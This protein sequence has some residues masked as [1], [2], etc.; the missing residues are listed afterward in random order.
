VLLRVVQQEDVDTVEAHPGERVLEA[1]PH[2]VT[3][4]VPD[5]PMVRGHREQVRHV[6]AGRLLRLEHPADLRRHHELVPRPAPQEDAELAFRPAEA[7][8]R[9]DVVVADARIPP[10]R[11]GRLGIVARDRLEQAADRATAEADLR[12]GESGTARRDLPRAHG[13]T[14]ARAAARRQGGYLT[15]Q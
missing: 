2:A 13:S 11:Q 5:P 6:V 7:V 14:L 15:D 12:H 4:E 1:A 3:G 9:G 10:R 8:V